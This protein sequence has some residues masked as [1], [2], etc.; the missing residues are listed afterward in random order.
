[1][2]AWAL[3]S[4]REYSVGLF[5]SGKSVIRAAPFFILC[6]ALISLSACS[7]LN[8]QTYQ[9]K[10]ID[11]ETLKPIE[12]VVVVAEW[13][14]C[15][16]GIGAGEL[17][18][19]EMV[20]ETLTDKNGDW[21]I[22][23]PKGV[24]TQEFGYIR[25]I[26]SFVIHY[27]ISP[28]FYTYKRGYLGINN[29]LGGFDAFP[30]IKKG[31]DTEGIILIR[32]G[33]TREETHKF[34]EKYGGLFWPFIPMKDPKK[35]LQSLDFD[36]K[37]PEKIEVIESESRLFSKQYIVYG[38]SRAKTSK[39]FMDAPSLNLHW[40][41][42]GKLKILPRIIDRDSTEDFKGYDD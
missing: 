36:F 4:R 31:Q 8:N 13:L 20:K 32:P 17:C 27:T 41:A 22:T 2:S 37:Y 24:D 12:G 40:K 16:P 9:G 29:A 1:M 39:D 10:I 34:F 26:S 30:Y 3:C 28:H 11:A 23:G 42:L 21:S 7:M 35:R 38:L 14:E 5:L 19:F 33:D 6:I 18:D 15:W 25:A